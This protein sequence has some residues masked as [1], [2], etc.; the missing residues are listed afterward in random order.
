M[1]TGNNGK[2]RDTREK[3]ETT[4]RVAFDLTPA[5]VEEINRILDVTDLGSKPEVFRRAFT[6]LRIHVDAAREGRKIYMVDP[7]QPSDRYLITLPFTVSSPKE[8]KE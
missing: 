1:A 7:E 8:T 6:L 5:M 2:D 4:A 3:T